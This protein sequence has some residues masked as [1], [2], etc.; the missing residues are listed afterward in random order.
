MRLV[1]NVHDHVTELAQWMDVVGEKRRCGESENCDKD[2]KHR[3]ASLRFSFRNQPGRRVSISGFRY[4][5]IWWE[6]PRAQNVSTV[7]RLISLGL[8]RRL[9]ERA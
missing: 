5:K 4:E 6:D 7:F 8:S 9:H 1:G 3:G 2:T